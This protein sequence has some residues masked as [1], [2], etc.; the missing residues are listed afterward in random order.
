MRTAG[1]TEKDFPVQST[2]L[3]KTFLQAVFSFMIFSVVVILQNLEHP[4]ILW[5]IF[6]FYSICMVIG[7][8]INALVG[9]LRMAT[10]HFSIDE[11]FLTVK[12][13]IIQKQEKHLPYAVIQH[14]LIKQD[15]ADRVLGLA[16]FAV[17]NATRGKD[18]EDAT[19]KVFGMKL[20]V[21]AQQRR[22]QL[23]SIGFKGNRLTIPG[24]L[25]KDA[26]ALRT[27]IL[28]KMKENP[29]DDN[30]SGL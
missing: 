30:A 14:I 29:L 27:I 15:L 20:K 21:S 17:E 5:K 1:G 10:F 24:M 8:G 11:K 3:F 28:Q 18:N 9:Y 26:A 6:L 25:A 13:G 19:Q 4:K 7:L 23:Q 2:W 16:T 12:Q 22:R